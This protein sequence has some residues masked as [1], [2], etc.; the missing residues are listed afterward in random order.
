M[1]LCHFF[2]QANDYTQRQTEFPKIIFFFMKILS[3]SH[4]EL[5]RFYNFFYLLLAVAALW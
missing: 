5:F 3:F 4:D 1:T 2:M